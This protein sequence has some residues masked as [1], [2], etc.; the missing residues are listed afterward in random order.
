MPVTTEVEFAAAVPCRCSQPFIRPV[1]SRRLV[2]IENRK[3]GVRFITRLEE[4]CYECGAAVKPPNRIGYFVEDSDRKLLARA[5][6]AVS[7]GGTIVGK[8][9]DAN[10]LRLVPWSEV[11]SLI[12]VPIGRSSHRL[13]SMLSMKRQDQES[14]TAKYLGLKHG[15]DSTLAETVIS[16]GEIRIDRRTVTHIVEKQDPGHYDL[17]RFTRYALANPVEIWCADRQGVKPRKLRFISL[18]Q[19]G[20]TLETHLA[21]VDEEAQRLITAYKWEPRPG[22][23]PDKIERKRRGM[24][25]YLAWSKKKEG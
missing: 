21:I 20:N 9:G 8:Y 18:F 10:N 6:E 3:T 4:I 24:A 11:P 25:R 14:I 22:D 5:Y 15:E 17:L 7:K 13:R 2:E 1:V 16:N 23:P 19:I 12:D